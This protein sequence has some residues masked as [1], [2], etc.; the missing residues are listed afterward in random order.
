MYRIFHAHIFQAISVALIAALAG[1]ASAPPNQTIS[2]DTR[3]RLA[4]ALQAS[5]D[6]SNAA[7]VRDQTAKKAGQPADPL[8][9]ATALI[10]AGQSD[11]GMSEAKAALAAHGD[12]L[13]FA[14]EVGRLAVRPG[15]LADAGGVYQ[16]IALRHPDSAEALNGKGV[17]L[18]QRGDLNGAIDA[19]RRALAL[20]PQ[21]VPTRNNLA[22]AMLLSGETDAALSILEELD[23][24]GG[25][26]QVK[27]TLAMAR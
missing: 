2:D 9:H 7:I 17:V 22:L 1:C 15:R 19:F 26:P 11:Q 18:A 16:Q 5:G 12:D 20:R 25:S 13:A 27:A 21:D 3:I 14:L 24:S 23:R 4:E 10:A 8:T 6:P